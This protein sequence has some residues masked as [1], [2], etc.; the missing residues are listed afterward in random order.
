MT[1]PGENSRIP[2]ALRPGPRIEGHSIQ[3]DEEQNA[4]VIDQKLIACT[5]TEYRVLTLLLEQADRCVL[6][7]QLW[8]QFQDE[9]LNDAAQLKQVRTRIIHLMS[10]LRAKIWALGLDVVAV[11]NYGYILL[12]RP[13]D[14]RSLP[15][16]RGADLAASVDE[17]EQH[18]GSYQ[19]W[20]GENDAKESRNRLRRFGADGPADGA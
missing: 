7:A 1:Q 6:F 14:H 11:M 16:D 9:P 5:P 17:T 15:T 8:E 10:D 3:Q 19:A 4:Y 20:K 18:A 12:S 13:P 2:G